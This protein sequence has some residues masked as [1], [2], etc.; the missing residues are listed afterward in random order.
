MTATP[1]PV[2]AHR[3]TLAE[4]I[5]TLEQ[6]KS[7]YARTVGSGENERESSG[8]GLSAIRKDAWTRYGRKARLRSI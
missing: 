2:K 7:A 3:L 5:N 1:A 6:R 8:R 4:A